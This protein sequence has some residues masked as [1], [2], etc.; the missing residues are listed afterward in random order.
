MRSKILTAISIL[1]CVCAVSVAFS[2]NSKIASVKETQNTENVIT[3]SDNR[4]IKNSVLN[5]RFLNMLNHS[6]VYDGDFY[7]D[8]ALVNNSLLAL[9]ELAEDGFVAENYISDYIF[10]MYGKNISDFSGIN[11]D[12]EQKQGF[13]C[14]VPCGYS[15]YDHKIKSVTDNQDGSYTVVTDVE[16]SLDD[17]SV[18]SDTATTVF[19]RNTESQFG[20]NIVYSEIGTVIENTLNC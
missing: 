8:E 11:A 10:N 3:V 7:D 14:V 1:L 6:F 12:F 4:N 2:S 20:F 15:I 9:L 19:L 16:I 18:V 17:G 5:A 13:V